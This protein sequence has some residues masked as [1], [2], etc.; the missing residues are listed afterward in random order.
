MLKGF[1]SAQNEIL[2]KT[3]RYISNFSKVVTISKKYMARQLIN[4]HEAQYNPREQSQQ[5]ILAYCQAN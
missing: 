3:Q 2:R 1:S 5:K 4:F